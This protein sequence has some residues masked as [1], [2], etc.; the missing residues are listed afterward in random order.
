MIL[1]VLPEIA[2]EDRLLHQARRGDRAALSAIYNAYY[3]PVYRFIRM[4]TDAAATAEDLAADVFVELVA[5]LGQGKGP[6]D[7]LRGWIFRVARNLLYD[8]HQTHRGFTET[9]LD[10]WLPLPVEDGPEAAALHALRSDNA[11]RALHQLTVDQQDV[12]VLRF[13]H[14]LS[15]QETADI[16]GKQVNAVKQLQLRA[17]DSLRRALRQMGVSDDE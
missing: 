7:R 10:E 3:P 1:L 15:L 5:A 17:L 11:R 12:L 8:H 13:G 2:E 9:V 14:M 16:L 4:R 6:R